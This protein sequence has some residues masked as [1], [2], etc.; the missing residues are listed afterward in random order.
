MNQPVSLQTLTTVSDEEEKLN[1]MGDLVAGEI[2]SVKV[3]RR[4]VVDSA[5]LRG[6]GQ[7]GQGLLLQRALHEAARGDTVSDDRDPMLRRWT[8]NF[9]QQIL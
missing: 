1:K 8:R 4:P 6:R 5:A 3:G 7:V 2:E 9:L